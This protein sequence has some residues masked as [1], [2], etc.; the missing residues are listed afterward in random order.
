MLERQIEPFLISRSYSRASARQRRK[1][2]RSFLA[3]VGDTVSYESVLDWWSTTERLAPASRKAHLTVVRLFL[4]YLVQ[5]QIVQDNYASFISSP[6]VHARPPVVLTREE[7]Q[8]VRDTARTKLDKLII[9]LQLG[10]G[11]RSSDVAALKIEDIDWSERTLTVEGK[12]G[13][14]RVVPF[15]VSLEPLLR[16]VVDGRAAGYLVVVDGWGPQF[17]ADWVRT[18]AQ[19]VLITAGVKR[20]ALDCKSP[21]VLRRTFATRLIERGV[22]ITVVQELLGHTSLESTMRYV[23][24]AGRDKLLSA[25]DCGPYGAA[26]LPIAA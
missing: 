14:V 17:R 10:C 1:I 16:A 22:Q 4:E 5:Q 20:A 2:L 9:A 15:P 25:V 19:A 11:F 23:G 3:V 26:D 21:H 6:K 18:R 7:E 12:G 8:A 13:K 24:A